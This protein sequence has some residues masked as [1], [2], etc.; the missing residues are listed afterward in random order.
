MPVSVVYG[1]VQVSVSL[2]RLFISVVAGSLHKLCLV[3][4]GPV[5]NTVEYEVLYD[6]ANMNMLP[7]PRRQ[8]VKDLISGS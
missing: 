1:M 3:V 5:H 4:F 8:Y 2:L 7:N 6:F